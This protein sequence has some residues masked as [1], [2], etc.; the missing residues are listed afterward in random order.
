MPE[1]AKSQEKVPRKEATLS[2][3][4]R[5][6]L[7]LLH[8]VFFDSLNLNLPRASPSL[9]ALLSSDHVKIEFVLKAFNHPKED[10]HPE[11]QSE[12]LRLRWMTFRFFGKCQQI[13]FTR[14]AIQKYR[15]WAE[16]IP[17]EEQ[18]PAISELQE[19]FANF[20]TT[21]QVRKYQ[22]ENL[23]P[24]WANTEYS[25]KNTAFFRRNGAGLVFA[26]T[27]PQR[28]TEMAMHMDVL[29]SV[30]GQSESQIVTHVG[31]FSPLSFARGC[32]IPEKLLHGPWTQERGDFL[33]SLLDYSV[34]ID[35]VNSTRGEVASEGLVDAI[36]A[37]STRAVFALLAR[38]CFAISEL[39]FEEWPP[40]KMEQSQDSRQPSPDGPWVRTRGLRWSNSHGVGVAPTKEHLRVAIL[41]IGCDP[42][43]VG[44]LF[45]TGNLDGKEI[46]DDEEIIYWAL[47]KQKEGD[48]RGGWLLDCLDSARSGSGERNSYTSR[49]LR[50][51]G[52]LR[53]TGDFPYLVGASNALERGKAR[54]I[55]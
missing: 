6:P 19:C 22:Q 37:N 18:A 29:E 4:E 35:F 5:L 36:R 2:P 12:I 47:T 7:E 42:Y 50:K 38:P 45:A 41:E 3:L 39:D 51:M 48:S 17:K 20:S 46:T 43:I 53:R 13:S 34:G 26:L 40:E 32:Q 25:Q 52:N 15:A 54:K 16:D 27:I 23:D 49:A 21:G 33:K 28:G 1:A 8:A 10:G 9:A 30:G 24:S 44:R 14:L 11:L 31:Y 55:L